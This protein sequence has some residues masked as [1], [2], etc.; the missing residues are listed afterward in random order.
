MLSRYVFICIS[1][2]AN[3]ILCY[4]CFFCMC[5]LPK[6]VYECM[7]VVWGVGQGGPCISYSCVC[8]R[9]GFEHGIALIRRLSH[10][11]NTA[12]GLP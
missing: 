5:R 4:N 10:K 6:N 8:V 7:D 12:D 1:V 2:F 11:I 3:R 9:C